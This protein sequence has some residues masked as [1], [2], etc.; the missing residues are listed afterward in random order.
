MTQYRILPPAREELRVAARWYEQ[1]REGLGH[2]LIDEFEER[3]A[4]ALAHPQAGT[5]VG[6]TTQGLPIRRHR[7]ARFAR[8][9]ILMFVDEDEFSIKEF[10][11]GLVIVVVCGGISGS[12]IALDFGYV[13]A[14]VWPIGILAFSFWKKRQEKKPE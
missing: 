12:G 11:V 4:L 3:L 6:S 5:I 7:L 9:S 14:W 10:L 1:Q 13:T 8:Y 2:A